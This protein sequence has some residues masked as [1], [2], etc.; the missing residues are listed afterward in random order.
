MNYILDGPNQVHTGLTSFQNSA[1][2]RS[3][4][5]E[6]NSSGYYNGG[7]VLN[8]IN[9]NVPHPKALAGKNQ[10]KQPMQFLQSESP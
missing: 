3:T 9:S 6:H 7:N 2:K 8:M 1:Q 4:G 10:G 5:E